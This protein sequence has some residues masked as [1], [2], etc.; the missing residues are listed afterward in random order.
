M[1][2]QISDNA[3]VPY[4]R[5]IYYAICLCGLETVSMVVSSEGCQLMRRQ[6]QVLVNNIV[7]L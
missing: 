2:G 4:D 3:T 6:D 1:G 7:L 5:Y